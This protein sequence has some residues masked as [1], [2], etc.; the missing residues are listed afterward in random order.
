MPGPTLPRDYR[1]RADELLDTSFQAIVL[2]WDGTVVPDRNAD[3]SGARQRIEA[4]CDRGIH[5]FI[6]SGTHLANVDGQLR[7]RPGGRGQL[8]LCCNRGSEVFA[9]TSEGPQLVDRRTATSKEDRALDRASEQTVGQLRSRG[10]GAKVVSQ[11]LNRRK[12]DLIPVPAWSDPVKADIARLAQAVAAEL[13][14]AGIADLG[15]VVGI[16][17]DAALAAGLADARI[18][19]DVKHVEIGL[20]DKSDSA[21]WAAAWLA[22]RGITGGLV[23]IGGDEFGPVGGVAG[24]DSLM[25][26]DALVRAPVVSVGVEPGGVPAGVVHVGGGPVRCMELLDAQL[27]RR[28]Q[29]RVPA[30]DHDPAWVL[31]LPA[32]RGRERVAESLGTLGNG[33][34]GT[35]G[36]PEEAGPGTAPLFLV[37]GVYTADGHLLPGPVW[38]GFDRC[39]SHPRRAGRRLLDLRGATLVHQGGGGTG[40]RSLRFV[41]AA[42]PHAMALR[43]EG[44]PVDLEPGE[45][46]R[47]PGERFDFEQA[48]QD[49]A[50]AAR[51]GRDGV[52]IAVAAHDQVEEADGRRTIERIAAWDAVPGC[53][54]SF[55]AAR[56][57]LAEADAS[58]FEELLAEHREEWARRWGD[59]G[60]EI[61]GEPEAELAARFAVFHLLNAAADSGAAAVG[62]RG[63]TGRAYSG[64]VFWDADVFVLPVLAALR[65]SAA[66]AILQYRIDRLPAARAMAKELGLRGA[67]FPWESAG[68]GQDVTPRT[69]RG[70]DHKIVQISTGAHEE[71]V[72]ADVAWAA[73]RYASWTG[74]APFLESA[75]RDLILDTARYWAS[76]IRTGPDG[77]AHISGVMGPDEYHPVVDDNA[78]TN[79]MARWNLRRG[80]D[81]AERSG[82]A[83]DADE[84]AGWRDQARRLV[85]GWNPRRG[86]Y[87]Q[88]AGYFDLEPLVMSQVAPPPSAVDVVLGTERVARSQLIKQADVLMLHHLVPEEVIAGSLATCLAFYEPRTAHGSSLSPAIHASL[89]ARAGQPD[90][91]LELFRLAARLDLDDITGTSAEGLHLA[92]MGGVWQALAF[93]FLGLRPED[94][95]LAVDPRLPTAWKALGL[96]FRFGG[97]AIRVRAEHDRVAISC[98][99]PLVV[100]VADRAPERL[101]P[102][103]TII[104]LEPS[105][106]PRRHR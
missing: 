25:M 27:L 1:H 41:S 26:V 97:K 91:A 20:T 94:G 15:E 51:T 11:R 62:A 10:I 17:A 24:S 19:S 16:A 49:S 98:D 56:N 9:I 63:F 82:D 65:P 21:E 6:V 58:G 64:H 69:A 87:E 96:G 32:G 46:L 45:P 18:T 89:L 4:L 55:D 84:A 93:G 22:R 28:E 5:V 31:T 48:R 39:G 43:V 104:P 85:D 54:A 78:Y 67:R 42:A 102:S 33:W 68:D 75:G 3:A 77:T 101:E 29:R 47:S 52:Q 73:A 88:F 71:H 59:V 57:R 72:V 90:R 80:A 37:N 92:T 70:R 66:R 12:I 60:V 50:V 81:L 38:T 40:A 86:L 8:H 30:I 44:A 83:G 34:A 23:L 35:R 7:A 61:E 79:V 74:D 14:S 106:K 99:A 100:R 53:E 2:D 13:S 95:G 76:R 103:D 36:S 105:P